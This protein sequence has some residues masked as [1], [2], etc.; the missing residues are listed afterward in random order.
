MEH[1]QS[2]IISHQIC[3]YALNRGRGQESEIPGDVL[4]QMKELKH[5]LLQKTRTSYQAATASQHQAVHTQP[6]VQPQYQDPWVE[7]VKHSWYL[8]QPALMYFFK[9]GPFLHWKREILANLGLFVANLLISNVLLRD[10]I[11]GKIDKYQ[12]WRK[13][14][15]GSPRPTQWGWQYLGQPP[16]EPHD[17]TSSGHR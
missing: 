10:K 6:K 14:T 17:E 5:N 12:V 15:L 4:D 1:K 8:S 16:H 7:Y 9:P 2:G 13:T 3:W 11:C